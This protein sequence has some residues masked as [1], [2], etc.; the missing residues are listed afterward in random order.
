MKSLEVSQ[1]H[2]RALAAHMVALSAE[3]LSTLD[4][5]PVFP[6]TSGAETERLFAEDVPEHGMGNEA[7]DALIHVIAHCRAQNGRFFG[8]VQGSGDPIAAL[9]DL[10]A[11]ILNQNMTAWRSSPAGVAIERTVVRWL[12][13]AIG[14]HNFLGT[15]TGE[16]PPPT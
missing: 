11:S 8:Y 16:V 2:F 9:A 4:A 10:M 6:T 1:E 7:F 14:C 12:A 15:L 3:Y 5:R 13:D